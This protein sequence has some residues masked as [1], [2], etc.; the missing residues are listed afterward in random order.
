MFV[1][2][3][4]F[5][6]VQILMN[7]FLYMSKYLILD[8]VFCFYLLYPQKLLN[9]MSFKDKFLELLILFMPVS[10]LPELDR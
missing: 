7:N 2:T 4:F 3:I 6:F 9:G 1:G 5:F 10:T 8:S